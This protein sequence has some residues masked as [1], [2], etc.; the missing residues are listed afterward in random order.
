MDIVGVILTPT[1]AQAVLYAV[2]SAK[3]TYPQQEADLGA[4]YR[5]VTEAMC[6]AT[7]GV[8]R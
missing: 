6:L 4:V 3:G 2:C 7:K 1:E 8:I 5:R